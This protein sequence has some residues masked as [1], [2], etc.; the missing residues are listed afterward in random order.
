MN[1]K[2]PD[3]AVA[4]LTPQQCSQNAAAW[5]SCGGEPHAGGHARVGRSGAA[6]RPANCVNTMERALLEY[7]RTIQDEIAAL[8]A[9]VGGGIAAKETNDSNP[10]SLGIPE[11]RL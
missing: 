4:I 7:P 5:G 9:A 3:K 1:L 10:E 2:A 11:T 8:K 6:G